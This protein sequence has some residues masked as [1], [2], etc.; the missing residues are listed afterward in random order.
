MS[1]EVIYPTLT[2]NYEK[3]V[4][5]ALDDIGLP[6]MLV[7]MAGSGKTS[8]IYRVAKRRGIEIEKFDSS[9]DYTSEEVKKYL[10]FLLTNVHDE[11]VVILL[12]DLEHCILPKWLEDLIVTSPRKQRRRNFRLIATSNEYWKM[13]QDIRDSFTIIKSDTRMGS[14]AREIKKLKL[15][16]PPIVLQH[17]INCSRDLRVLQQLL[18][19]PSAEIYDRTGEYVKVMDF[20]KSPLESEI[21]KNIYLRNWLLAN[22]LNEDDNSIYDKYSFFRFE[23]LG[24][25]VLADRY[26]DDRILHALSPTVTNY[27]KKL[28][29][30]SYN[31]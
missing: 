1:E 19:D 24:L 16:I 23:T 27:F 28:I 9:M 29:A 14:H 20:L 10:N 13:K 21:P 4:D 15:K 22:A 26:K 30:P 18:K 31:R 12:D 2:K 6:I 5:D 8:S 17:W 3:A 25:V 11:L 7:G